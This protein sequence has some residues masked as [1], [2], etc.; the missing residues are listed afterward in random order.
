MSPRQRLQ[1]WITVHWRVWP[2]LYLRQ[3]W[4]ACVPLLLVVGLAVLWE[5][6]HAEHTAVLR[7]MQGYQSADGVGCCSERDCVPWP[8]ALL[9]M[10]EN[11]VMV[12]IGDAVVHLPTKSVHATQDGQTYWC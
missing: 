5:Y 6:S 10:T 7:W 8:V 11:E 9:H 3:A 1:R 4:M 2:P 12:R